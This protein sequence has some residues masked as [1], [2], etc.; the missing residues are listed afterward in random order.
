M[1]IK[2]KYSN[3]EVTVV[4]EPAKCIHSTICWKKLP[5]VFD[6]RKRPWIT[7]EGADT[8]QIVEQVKTCPSGALTYFM[9]D[10]DEQKPET[11]TETVIELLPNGPLLVYGTIKIKDSEG[12]E[13]VK[14]Q[15]TALCR[16]GSSQNKPY[17][18][19]SHV[20]IGFTA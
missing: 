8:Q 11:I 15:T 1:E 10:A 6:P 9:D 5:Q 20:R 17:C 3:G 13:T 19:G 4:W 16:C 2:K 7:P 18:D 14:N 12:N